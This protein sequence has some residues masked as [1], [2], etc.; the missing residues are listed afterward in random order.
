MNFWW[1]CL[2]TFW[3][4]DSEVGICWNDFLRKCWN[5][6]KLLNLL[7]ICDF[8]WISAVYDELLV[9]FWWASDEFLMSFWWVFA[10]FPLFYYVSGYIPDEFLMGL[11]WVSDEFSEVSDEFMMSFCWIY[12]RWWVSDE[13]LVSCWWVSVEFRVLRL[14]T[15]STK[16]QQKSPKPN[17]ISTGI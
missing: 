13:F 2:V 3:E 17:R 10:D 9:S 16:S 14:S 6:E 8:W 5:K 4:V 7:T 1:F 15:D 12:L 11:C